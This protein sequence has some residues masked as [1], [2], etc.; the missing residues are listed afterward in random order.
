[1]CQFK[2]FVEQN[3]IGRI[4]AG[5][6]DGGIGWLGNRVDG[7]AVPERGAADQGRPGPNEYVGNDDAV[8]VIRLGLGLHQPHAIQEPEGK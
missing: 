1:M 5:A 6:G 4:S 3:E 2:Q 7:G 8:A